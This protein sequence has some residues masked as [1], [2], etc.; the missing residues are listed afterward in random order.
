[1]ARAL[2]LAPSG[3]YLAAREKTGCC[4]PSMLPP[5]FSANA[6]PPRSCISPPKHNALDSQSPGHRE[7][8]HTC[9]HCVALPSPSIHSQAQ[10]Q[11]PDATPPPCMPFVPSAGP[12][13]FTRPLTQRHRPVPATL[14]MC[15]LFPL[16]SL[17][18]LSRP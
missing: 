9:P 15:P 5:P 11:R 14:V 7:L 3:F 1:M 17:A 12:I 16:S 2:A 10:R 8:P 18:H 4:D 13:L 6:S